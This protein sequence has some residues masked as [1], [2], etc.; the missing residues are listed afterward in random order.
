MAF[1]QGTEGDGGELVGADGGKNAAEAADRSADETTNEGFGHSFSFS[2]V[3][4]VE[5]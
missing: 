5:T 2:I 3:G 1:Y 4:A